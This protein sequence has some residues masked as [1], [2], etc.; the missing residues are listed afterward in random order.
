[1][2]RSTPSAAYAAARFYLL[3][4]ALVEGA[5]RPSQAELDWAIDLLDT[6]NLPQEVLDEAETDHHRMLAHA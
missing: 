3:L 4:E 6:L 1:M 5:I 2:E